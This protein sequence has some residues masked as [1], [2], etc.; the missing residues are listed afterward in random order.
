MRVL[1]AAAALAFILFASPASA[2]PITYDFEEFLD[3]DSVSTLLAPLGAT[4]TITNAAAITAG[5]SLNDF[6]FPPVSGS[7]VIFDSGGAVSVAFSQ[8]VSSFSGFFTYNAP[9][10]VTAFLGGVQVGL[11]TSA[12]T[13]NYVSSG[14]AANEFLELAGVGLFDSVVIAGDSGGGSF[15][16]DDMTIDVPEQT[17]S[18]PEPG[19]LSLLALGAAAALLRRRTR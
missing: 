5:I 7:N 15:V 1:S 10:S 12:F 8:A 2:V 11:L 16:L 18:V 4:V 13:E 14:N 3:G 19:T 6:D 9:V 17:S